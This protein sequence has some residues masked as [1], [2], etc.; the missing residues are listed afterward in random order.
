MTLKK[1]AV[2]SIHGEDDRKSGGQGNVAGLAANIKQ[3]GLINP[4]SV[5]EDGDGYKIVAGRRRLSAVHY[6]GMNEIEAKVYKDVEVPDA[7]KFA[8]AE[9]TAREEM[10]P[11]DEGE[12]YSRMMRDGDDAAEIGE[13]FCRTKAQVYQRARLSNLIPDFKECLKSGKMSLSVAA[14]CAEVPEKIQRQIND[15]INPSNMKVVP[16]YTISSAIRGCFTSRLED[17]S[18]EKCA[19]CQKRTHY[20]DGTLFPDINS[21][22]DICMDRKCW[23]KC[24]KKEMDA[25]WKA[26]EKKCGDCGGLP[27]LANVSDFRP[28][29]DSD[30]ISIELGGAEHQIINFYDCT[31]LDEEDDEEQAGWR[32]LGIVK[33]GV[34][35][36]GLGFVK[37]E[38]VLRKDIPSDNEDEDDTDEDKETL[39]ENFPDSERQEVEKK[40]QDGQ[41]WQVGDKATDNFL[42]G[43]LFTVGLGVDFSA[44]SVRIFLALILALNYSWKIYERLGLGKDAGKPAIYRKLLELEPEDFDKLFLETYIS[45]D[46]TDKEYIGLF[47]EF[48]KDYD[49]EFCAE[50]DLDGMSRNAVRNALESD[51][52]EGGNGNGSG[53]EDEDEESEDSDDED[54]DGDEVKN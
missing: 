28:F 16:E 43:F 9:N 34:K 21:T 53:N 24:W 45:F 6:L 15:N 32:G 44:P 11:L 18:C 19:G 30:D 23:I 52:E 40:I 37:C 3:Y 31:L 36:A 5:I 25:L 8:I 14:M 20:S 26:M 42:K 48:E 2:S 54:A 10:S 38:Y 33:N 29:F 35:Y 13:L 17:F 50:L 22:D 39:L 51:E 46:I 1:I 12:L 41:G 4:I 27:I 49:K 7:E 47:K